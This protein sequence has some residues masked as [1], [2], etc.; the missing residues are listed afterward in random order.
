MF[1]GSLTM[2]VE[3][4]CEVLLAVQLGTGKCRRGPCSSQCSTSGVTKA[5]VYNILSAGWCL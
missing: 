5:V 3:S 4:F 2:C 1:K